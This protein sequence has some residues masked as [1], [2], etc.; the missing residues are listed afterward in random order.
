MIFGR[1]ARSPTDKLFT[2]HQ[3]EGA[4]GGLYCAGTRLYNTRPDRFTQPDTIVPGAE[5]PQA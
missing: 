1:S 2:S 5:N 3:R 4:R